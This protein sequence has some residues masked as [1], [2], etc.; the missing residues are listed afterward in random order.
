MTPKLLRHVACMKCE[1]NSGEA[2][3]W[4]EKLCDEVKTV[5]NSHIMVS[6]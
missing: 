4:E 2:A 6:E 1:G 5:W 3:E